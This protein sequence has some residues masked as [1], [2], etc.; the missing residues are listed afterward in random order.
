MDRLRMRDGGSG[1]GIRGIILVIPGDGAADVVLFVAIGVGPDID[2]REE[3]QAVEISK[4]ADAA[5]VLR[6]RRIILFR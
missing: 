2:A 3:L 5:R 1:A 6:L 4:A